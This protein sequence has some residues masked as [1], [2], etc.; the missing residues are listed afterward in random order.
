MNLIRKQALV[1]HPY[2]C[3]QNISSGLCRRISV[4]VIER[5]NWADKVA[6]LDD[7]VPHDPEA[8]HLQIS[9]SHSGGLT[10]HGQ[11]RKGLIGVDIVALDELRR[12]DIKA[13]TSLTRPDVTPEEI[14]I[15]S[16]RDLGFWWAATE[17]A[18]KAWRGGLPQLIGRFQITLAGASG[19]E[20]RWKDDLLPPLFFYPLVLRQDMVGMLATDGSCADVSMIAYEQYPTVCQA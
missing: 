9:R 14:G 17:A 18:A 3:R 12:S 4:P 15:S 19:A 5:P 1:E 13:L 10:L 20:I 8:P 11:K 2:R 6:H 7:G 16:L